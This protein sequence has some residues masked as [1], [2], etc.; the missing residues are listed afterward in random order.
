M[1]DFGTGRKATGKQDGIEDDSLI[2][3]LEC[4]DDVLAKL[5]CKIDEAQGKARRLRKRVDQLM[6]DSQ[7]AHTS[8]MPQTVAP[9]HRDSTI[10]N[11]K[12]CA[13]IEDPLARRQREAS[14]PIGRQCIP[15][16][17]IEHLLVPQ[18]Q[19]AGQ[20]LTNNSPISSQS[21]RFHPILEDVRSV[22][23]IIFLLMKCLL[24][25]EKEFE[26]IFEWLLCSC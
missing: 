23:S 6:W 18:T 24:G 22:Y 25:V 13:L 8:S 19:I 2:S 9:C 1:L 14:V 12:K 7:T 11:G 4:S 10:Q 26:K 15:G 21:L 16:D 5:L 3:E 20:R 17:H